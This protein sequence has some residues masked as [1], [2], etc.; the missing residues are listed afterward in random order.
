M[1]SS[2]EFSVRSSRAI[3]ELI[4]SPTFNVETRPPDPSTV[5]PTNHTEVRAA[6]LKHFAPPVAEDL[7]EHYFPAE[8]IHASWDSVGQPRI[9][10]ELCLTNIL[11]ALTRRH[12][13][14]EDITLP[15]SGQEILAR[16][17]VVDQ[18]PFSG[19]GRVTGI[20]ISGGKTEPEFWYHDTPRSCLT[21]LEL[22][23]GT[24]TE[25]ALATK[26]A[27]GW[28]YLFTDVDLSRPEFHA[29]SQNLRE[30]L[31]LFSETFPEYDYAPLV[32]RLEARL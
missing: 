9:S 23:Y 8:E 27:F 25:V 26:G 16:L 30:S 29:T 15:Q 1:P 12:P 22:G 18:E 6:L 28:Q 17:K 21:R 24:Y 4:D 20:R 10:G 19:T 3:K 31:A 11:V 2:E 14:L 7:Q 5:L 13:P 32:N